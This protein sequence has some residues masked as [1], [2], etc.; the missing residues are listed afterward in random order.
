LP[1]VPGAVLSI[2]AS[3]PSP[4][5]KSIHIGPLQL[6]FYGLMIALGVIAAVWL[7]QKR[8]S[9][10]GGH[11]DDISALALWAVPAGLVGAR[12]YHVATDWKSFEG[13][14]FDVVKVWQGGLGIPGGMLV[15]LIVGIIVARRRGMDFRSALDACVPALP[16]AQAIGRLGNYFNQELFGRPTT[17]PWGLRIDPQYRPVEYLDRTTFQPTFLYESLWNLALCAFLLWLDAKRVVRRGR[18][19]A[20]YMLGYGVG[21]LIVESMRSD[22][23]SL[24]WGVRV[25]IWTSLVLIAGGIGLLRIDRSQEPLTT[26]LAVGD[27]VARDGDSGVHDAVGTEADDADADADDVGTEAD[28]AEVDDESSPSDEDASAGT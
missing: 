17:L 16:L 27:A 9:A 25:N 19:I 13:R 2:V 4:S 7:A 8:W 3:I 18:L 10:R 26:E 1:G 20:V 28:D 12:L 11:P 15:G 23:A 21:R 22:P 24:I 5:S 6:R 14:W